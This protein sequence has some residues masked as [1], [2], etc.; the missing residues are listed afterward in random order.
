MECCCY[1][2][3][4]RDLLANGKTPY[5]R[6]FGEYFKGPIFTGGISPKL[7]ETKL[8]FVNSEKYNQ[9]SCLNML[10]SRGRNWNGDVLIADIEELEKLDASE[11]IP[12]DWIRK[13]SWLP[14]KRWRICFSCDRW[15]SN[16]IRKRLRI[17]RTRSEMG[18]HRKERI[19]AENLKAIGKSFNL[20]VQKMTKES[21]R[22]FV[23]TQKPG[24]TFIVIKLNRE[25]QLHVPRE[26]S[27]PVPL[28]YIDVIKSTH[29]DFDVAQVKRINDIGMSTEIDIC[30]IRGL[31]SRDSHHWTELLRKDISGP[32][33][34]WQKSKRHHVQITFGL[35]HG[36]AFEK[37]LKE[38][39]NKNGQS[40][41]RNPNTPENWEEL[42]YWSVWRRIQRHH[43]EC[44]AKVGD[45]KGS[46]NAM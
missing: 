16:I 6:R 39:K 38:E 20:K 15:I 13:K 9:E 37:P 24:K 19:S 40:R 21:V 7:R 10:W 25:V 22:I 45:I 29:T 32:G 27:F 23:L 31:V 26:E 18:T 17:P 8:E 11:F 43:E 28:T 33:R 30:R 44:K 41:N 4:V 1:L 46:C 34:D 3:N 36:Q 35:T 5:E 12:E 2:R 42:F 14:T